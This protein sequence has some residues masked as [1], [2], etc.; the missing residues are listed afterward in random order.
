MPR[1]KRK[2][3]YLDEDS[4]FA[5]KRLA[6]ATGVSEA[7]HIRRAV[8]KYLETKEMELGESSDP[9]EELIGLCDAPH[10]PTDASIHHDKYLP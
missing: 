9:L 2:Q 1:L 10:G 8:R 7:E 3:V 6:N 5:L 4:D